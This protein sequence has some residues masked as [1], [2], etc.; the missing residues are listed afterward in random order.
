MYGRSLHGNQGVSSLTAGGGRS[1]P[2]REGAE[3]KPVM[4]DEEKSDPAIVAGK[5][6]NKVERSAAEPVKRRAGAEGNAERADMHRTPSRASVPHGLARVRTAAR[7]DKEVRFT[8]L[9]HHV[10]VESTARCLL[11]A[12]TGCGAGC[13]W[14]DVACVWGRS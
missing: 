12:Q 13:G 11:L 9:L 8:A 4:N 1:G 5:P 14:R 3:L 7:L 10:N 6:T 2:H